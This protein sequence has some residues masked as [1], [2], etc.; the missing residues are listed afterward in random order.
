MLLSAGDRLV[1]VAAL[2]WA[3]MEH[4]KNA[5]AFQKAARP[6]DAV[7]AAAFSGECVRLADLLGKEK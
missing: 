6:V 4:E 5:Q 7:K 1:I 3:A 2:Q